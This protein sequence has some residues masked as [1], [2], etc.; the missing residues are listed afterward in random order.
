LDLHKKELSAVEQMQGQLEKD[1]DLALS[2]LNDLKGDNTELNEIIENQKAQ[3]ENTK[4]QDIQP[5]L[6]IQKNG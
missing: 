4:G 5:Y 2:S 6:E 1:Y 3:L